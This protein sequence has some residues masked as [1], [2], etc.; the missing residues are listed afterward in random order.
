MP[1]AWSAPLKQRYMDI[2]KSVLTA[3]AI[4]RDDK[5]ARVNYMTEMYGLF[6]APC[7]LVFTFDKSVPEG[8]AMLDV[9]LLLQSICLTAV[10]K[11]LGTCILAASVTY[12][13][14]LRELLPIP[15]DQAIAI[16]A[17]LGYPEGNAA[18]NC[19]ERQRAAVDDYAVWVK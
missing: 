15:Q 18:V 5:Q 9:G 8:Y 19:F 13:E 17:A 6:D 10:D 16:G 11:G 4:A 14:L 12:S 1:S 7:L 2:G 3:L